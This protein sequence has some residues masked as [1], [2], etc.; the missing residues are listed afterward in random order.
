MP[1]MSK[2]SMSNDMTNIGLYLELHFRNIW[3]Y[4]RIGLLQKIKHDG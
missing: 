2:L 1:K 3:L 4:T